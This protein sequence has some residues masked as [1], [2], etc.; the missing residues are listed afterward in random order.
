MNLSDWDLIM[1]D[2]SANYGMKFLEVKVKSWDSLLFNCSVSHAFSH[3]FCAVQQAYVWFGSLLILFIIN[4]FFFSHKGHNQQL[5]LTAAKLNNRCEVLMQL[6]LNLEEE[7]RHLLEQISRLMSQNEE[8]LSQT[9]E[10]KDQ[11]YT[12]QKQYT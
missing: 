8:L 6:K 1:W 5:D 9:L 10:S 11:I 7:N 3:T 12:E 2:F 4:S